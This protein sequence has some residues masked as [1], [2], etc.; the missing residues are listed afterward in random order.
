MKQ[1]LAVKTFEDL[2]AEL[3]E[4]ARTRPPGSGTVAALDGGVHGLGKKILEEAVTP[5]IKVG[6]S[7]DQDDGGDDDAA[8][9]KGDP[10]LD[11]ALDVLKTKTA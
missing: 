11:K 8:P 4:R 10:A 9:A 1:S 3:G 7:D 5:G 2:F 6:P